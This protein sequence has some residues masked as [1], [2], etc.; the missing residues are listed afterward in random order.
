[1]LANRSPVSR[2]VTVKGKPVW[3]EKGRKRW[4]GWIGLCKV[5][6]LREKEDICLICFISIKSAMMPPTRIFSV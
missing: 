2:G 1:M 4:S 3:V 6:I 5:L